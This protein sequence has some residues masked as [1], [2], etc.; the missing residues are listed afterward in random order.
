MKEGKEGGRQGGREE[1]IFDFFINLRRE[2]IDDG[3]QIHSNQIQAPASV[4]SLRLNKKREEQKREESK[5]HV[6]KS[7]F[8]VSEGK[9]F[10]YM[11]ILKPIILCFHFFRQD[12][13]VTANM[14]SSSCIH[15]CLGY[16][17]LSFCQRK[18]NVLISTNVES[19]GS[20]FNILLS[21]HP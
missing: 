21:L 1:V 11:H 2:R 20:V 9:Y 17:I 16:V 13:T 18:I 7:V 15:L 19:Y 3:C 5:F 14:D 8:S 10:S 6:N 12:I 4:N